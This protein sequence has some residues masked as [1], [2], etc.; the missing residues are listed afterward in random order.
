MCRQELGVT[1]REL[2]R[3]LR[4]DHG[5]LLLARTNM[6]IGDI[7]EMCGFQNQFHFSRCCS[8]AYGHSPRELRRQIRA[9]GDKPL[10]KVVGL[11]RLLQ[12]VG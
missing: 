12:I 11:R 2:L 3:H 1:P 4:L 10:S 8:Q 6:K 9:G 5:L 7:S